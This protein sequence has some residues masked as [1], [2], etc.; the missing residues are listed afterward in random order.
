MQLQAHACAWCDGRNTSTLLTCTSGCVQAFL[1]ARSL[2]H[3]HSLSLTHTHTQSLSKP[4]NRRDAATITHAYC[5]HLSAPTTPTMWASTLAASAAGWACTHSPTAT[6]A[7]RL[8][9][10]RRAPARRRLRQH[11]RAQCL[12]RAATTALLTRRSCAAGTAGTW[13]SMQTTSLRSALACGCAAAF[14]SCAQQEQ[15]VHASAPFTR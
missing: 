10:Q 13:A 8:V 12:P 2:S 9:V 5:P 6:S 11:L 7:W 4:R 1:L 15:G 3:T 14:G